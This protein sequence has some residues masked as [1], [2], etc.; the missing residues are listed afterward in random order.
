MVLYAESSA[1]LSWLFGE[2]RTADVT[3]ALESA[4]L[5]VTSDLTHIECTRAIH[6]AKEQRLLKA[7]RARELVT[8]Y[9]STSAQWDTLPIGERVSK[10]ACAPWP[11]EPVRALDAIHLASVLVAWDAWRDL[12]VLALDRRVRANL[13]ALRIPSL[14]VDK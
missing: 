14:P 10:L 4:T 8:V 5:V 12:H 2:R 11:V 3:S 9:A 6:R 13:T 7:Q 1:I